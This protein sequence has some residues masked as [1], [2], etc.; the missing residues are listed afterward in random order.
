MNLLY[1]VFE[2]TYRIV[3]D[4]GFF[5]LL[6]FFLAGLLHEF[7]D[8]ARIGRAL[9]ERSLK[10]ILKAAFV[11]GPLP[12]CSCG[13]LPMAVA[14]RKKGASREATVSFLIS[15]P[16]T[17]E[18]AILITYG[19]LGPVM[20]IVRPV[21]AIATAVVA[22]L[23]SLVAGGRDDGPEAGRDEAE[24]RP[25]ETRSGAARTDA[26]APGDAEVAGPGPA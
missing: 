7:V 12:L 10:S 3:L 13:V 1:R 26:R 9:G 25:R 14:L 15:T 11:G 24:P 20:A 17:G 8:T 4:S 23:V 5:I 16:E 21:V 6:G 19:L 2:E 18:E 22:G